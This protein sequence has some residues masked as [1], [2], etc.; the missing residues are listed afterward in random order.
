MVSVLEL[1][2]WVKS[3]FESSGLGFCLKHASAKARHGVC[4]MNFWISA[5]GHSVMNIILDNAHIGVIR[6]RVHQHTEPRAAGSVWVSSF[7]VPRAPN[8]VAEPKGRRVSD[9]NLEPN[10]LE[11]KFSPKK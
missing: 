9:P 6:D 8:P 11:T 4:E 3:C 5:K 10:D 7:P 2:V 1:R